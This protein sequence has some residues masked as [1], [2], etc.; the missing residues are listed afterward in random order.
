MGINNQY[1]VVKSGINILISLASFAIDSLREVSV[2]G[3]VF[4]SLLVKRLKRPLSGSEMNVLGE[5]L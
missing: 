4:G 1:V 2:G 5:L 3:A